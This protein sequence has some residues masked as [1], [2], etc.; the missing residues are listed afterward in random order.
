MLKHYFQTDN[1]NLPR[2]KKPE[3]VENQYNDIMSEICLPATE[4]FKKCMIKKYTETPSSELYAKLAGKKVKR[5][6]ELEY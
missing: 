6:D 4:Y 2:V 1:L 5:K 3:K